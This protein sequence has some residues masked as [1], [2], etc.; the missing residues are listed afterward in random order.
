MATTDEQEHQK[1]LQATTF[2]GGSV[3][4]DGN[5]KASEQWTRGADMR[6][7]LIG[8]FEAGPSLSGASRPTGT[9]YVA[10]TTHRRR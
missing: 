9:V 1:L 6:R 4:A 5:L 7:Q 2:Q 3:W 8:T 10:I